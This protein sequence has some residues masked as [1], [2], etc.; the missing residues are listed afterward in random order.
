MQGSPARVRVEGMGSGPERAGSR[1][2]W[3]WPEQAPWGPVQLF[4]LTAA[5][6][7]AGS[8]LAILLIEESGLSSVF[9]IPAG[10][11]VAFLL[12]VPRR[13]WWLV[14]LAAGLAEA[15]MDLLAGYAVGATAGYVAANMVEPVI[16]AL[17]V[18]RW[19]GL[20]DLARIRHLWGFLLGAV[21]VGPAIGAAVGSAP[22]NFLG[23][24]AFST[25]YWQWWLGDA[26]GV[27][28]VG[29]AIL[30]WGSSLDRRSLASAWGAAL[31]VGTLLLTVAV[32]ILTDL[33]LI[34]LVLIGVT[35]AGAVFG[36]RAVA[37]TALIVALTVAIDV[38]F[39]LG[40]LIPGMSEAEALIVIKLQLGVC[41]M[42][43]L[44]V[45][46]EAHE[47]EEASRAAVEASA[48]ARE[49]ERERRL[50]HQIA[51]RLQQALLPEIPLQHPHASIAAR[52]EAGSE[53]MV[54]G[55]DWYDVMTLPDGRIGITI[56]D[57]VGHGLEATTAM[58][59]LR[60]AVEVLTLHTDSP[61]QL[62]AYLDQ[63]A[64]GSDGID[65]AT[66]CYSILD[67]ISGKFTFASAGHPPMLLISPAG[68]ARWLE[69]GLSPPLH[70]S[71]IAGRAE[72]TVYLEP[73]SLLLGYSDGL[74]ERR[75]EDLNAGLDRLLERTRELA[76]RPVEEICDL[77][78]KEMGVASARGDDVVVLALRYHP[79]EAGEPS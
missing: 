21:L 57:V 16:G 45:A 75:D 19:C 48:R 59:R 78:V 5:A 33:P 30:V 6:Y 32:V 26:L 28:L 76:D 46:A 50:E 73:G 18:T 54:V 65:F 29:S 62:L 61:G 38:A 15:T 4:V 58:G 7:A 53:A 2:I 52:Y 12:R 3:R 8:Q 22:A 27:L 69:E 14:V 77:L 1:G 35:V 13:F 11:T 20:V 25:Q 72:A 63:Y 44:V 42:A 56:G 39:R 40:P 79:A 55:G 66:V 67:T 60:T 36:S 23:D 51:V 9:F 17:I 10:I 34:F 74:V 70:D 49:A 47:H 24:T 31:I 41:A 64:N 68:E 71:F 37:V 43:G